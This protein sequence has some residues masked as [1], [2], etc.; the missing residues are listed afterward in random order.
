MGVVSINNILEVF[1]IIL[2]KIKCC[3]NAS[4][5]CGEKCA[6]RFDGAEG[7]RHKDIAYNRYTINDLCA[8]GIQVSFE[9]VVGVFEKPTI[10]VKPVAAVRCIVAVVL[11]KC[12][13]NDTK[14]VIIKKAL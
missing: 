9:V 2:V 14:T 13:C 3:N 6:E 8:M 4:A 5:K 7:C 12:L 1:V 10:D 11:R